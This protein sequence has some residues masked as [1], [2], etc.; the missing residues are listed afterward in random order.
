MNRVFFPLE[1]DMIVSMEFNDVLIA[2]TPAAHLRRRGGAGE[3]EPDPGGWAENGVRSLVEQSLDEVCNKCPKGYIQLWA[4]VD[5]EPL[6]EHTDLSPY[7]ID[8]PDRL[9]AERTRLHNM[10]ES[11]NAHYERIR[12]QVPPLDITK[13]VTVQLQTY[14]HI[15]ESA[16]MQKLIRRVVYM[17]SGKAYEWKISS[18]TNTGSFMEDVIKKSIDNPFGLF[19]SAVYDKDW[20][21]DFA[22]TSFYVDERSSMLCNARE[23]GMIGNRRMPLSEWEGY[24]LKGVNAL[25]LSF[26]GSYRKKECSPGRNEVHH[27]YANGI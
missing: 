9:F 14:S 7:V 26:R 6:Y 15:W 5:Y 16:T 13:E 25:F 4:G 18:K 27:P 1:V 12:K 2:A 3:G 22:H 19:L 23:D 21:N 24:V 8:T 17:L 11:L 20:R 10:L